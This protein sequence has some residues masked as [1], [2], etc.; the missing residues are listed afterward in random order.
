[1]VAPIS[2]TPPT[3]VP[4]PGSPS[5]T[6]IEGAFAAA[7]VSALAQ[8]G[9]PAA[10]LLTLGQMVG[11]GAMSGVPGLGATANVGL[12]GGAPAQPGGLVMPVQGRVTSSFGPRIHPISGRSHSHSGLDIAAPAG[13][14]IGA[15]SAGTVTFAGVRGGY[16]NLVIIDH[17]DGRETRYAHADRLLVQPGQ[18]VFAGQQV[19][20]VG[21]TG[22]ATG[23]HLHLEVRLNG[24]AVDPAP[25]LGL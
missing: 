17:G 9:A 8:A 13:T 12:L 19:A 1:M 6:P 14:P 24:E 18:R 16:G 4:A 15:T 23:P 7:L 10:Q 5:T 21:A 25:L 22:S 2:A 3:G 11:G 20:T